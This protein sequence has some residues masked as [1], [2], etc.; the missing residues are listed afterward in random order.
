MSPQKDQDYFCEGL[1]EELINTLAQIKDLRVV[2]RTSA[3]ALTG[4]RFTL[5]DLL[6]SLAEAYGMAG[7]IDKGQEF[8]AQAL[9]EV[10]RG[11][12]RYF[13]AELYRI[14]GELLLKKA[15]RNDRAAM[16]KEAEAC[17]RQSL[18]VARRQEA[19]SFEL[20]TAVSLDKL[21]R[22]QGKGSEAR[23][24]LEDIYGW[25]TEGFD[26]ADL[27]EAKSLIEELTPS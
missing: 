27:K 21:L 18:A 1:A 13:E 12:E 24:L 19:K 26:Q 16:E 15:E 2:A 25:F 11:G 3:F 7:E 17:L 23:K 4:V 6:G 20:R 22:K 14:K 8:M 9:A 10:E 5:T